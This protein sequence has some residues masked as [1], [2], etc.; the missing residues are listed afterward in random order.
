MRSPERGQ[1]LLA[2]QA[3][4]AAEPAFNIDIVGRGRIKR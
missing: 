4:D 1:P 2:I 3:R